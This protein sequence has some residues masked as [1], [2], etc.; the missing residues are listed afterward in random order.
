MKTAA[1]LLVRA[2]SL[3]LLAIPSPGRP[4]VP[5]DWKPDVVEWLAELNE[6]QKA[7]QAPTDP[8]LPALDSL[9]A[10]RPKAGG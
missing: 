6:H 3:F 10:M 9:A 1:E 7:T 4:E 8:D 5:A 2:R